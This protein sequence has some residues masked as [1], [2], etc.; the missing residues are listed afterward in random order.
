MELIA[1][2]VQM[3]S[4]DDLAAN[5]ATVKALGDQAA[6]E[7]ANL[8][9][10]P[11]CFPFLG[12]TDTAK[13]AVAE[14]LDEAHPGPILGAL[15]DLA[16]RHGA[17]VIGGGLPEKIDGDPRRTWNTAVVVGPGGKIE[18]RYRKIHLFDIDIPGGPSHR[19]SDN[20]ASGGDLV[21]VPIGERRVGLSICYDVR[22]PEL[23]RRLVHDLGADV[24]VVPAAFTAVTGR[25]HWHVLLRARAIEDQCWVVAA[26]QHGRHNDK[27][28]TFGHSMVIDPWGT[29]VAERPEGDGVV[30]AKLDG[31]VIAKTRRN[32]PCRDHATL[33]PKPA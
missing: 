8:I 16:T 9:V 12:R 24:V 11:E 20:T 3:C 30:V 28:E 7:G 14:V 33:W 22:F 31:E 25:A 29:I 26:A 23:Y 27:R 2:A 6:A 32:L 15:C 19:E 5:L 18:A 10:L 17:W 1:A 13:L 4:K 21:V